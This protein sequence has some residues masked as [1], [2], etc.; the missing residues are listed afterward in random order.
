[1]RT[2]SKIFTGL[3]VIM[4]FFNC[5]DKQKPVY[6]APVPQSSKELHFDIIN[7]TILIK[8]AGYM[9]TCDSL[10]IMYDPS[11]SPSIQIFDRENGVLL[12]SAGERGPG[13]GELVSPYIF[14]FDSKNKIMY[15]LDSSKRSVLGFSLDD[16]M[17]NFKPSPQQLS[18][19][20]IETE[21]IIS[22]HIYFLKDSLFI[23]RS[24]P[25]L[26]VSPINY[27]N[28]QRKKYLYE[29]PADIPHDEWIRFIVYYMFNTVKPDGSKYVSATILGAILD[30]ISIDSAEIKLETRK[31]FYKPI[32]TFRGGGVSDVPE[33]IWGF[34]TL[35]ASDQFI[36][37]T[38]YAK[39]NPTEPP[40]VIW[41]FDWNGNP[42][43]SY[44]SK[45]CIERFTVDEETHEIYALV[46]NTDGE[47]ALAKGKID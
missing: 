44:S 18:F 29:A 7:D 32:Y 30:I 19:L 42:V 6:Q 15:I 1:M 2:G 47:Y 11:I 34:Y 41:Q 40:N 27:T 39:S 26:M 12:K 3:T 46:Y 38:I 43:T 35:Y 36:Y 9:T 4:L 17:Q 22:D 31:H 10:L 45:Y 28:Y 25:T 21:T 20:K 5:S 8:V 33:T 23:Y 14:S 24:G 13:P 16:I 37:A